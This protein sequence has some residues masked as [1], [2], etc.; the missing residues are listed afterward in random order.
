MEQQPKGKKNFIIEVTPE[1]MSEINRIWMHSDEEPVVE[2]YYSPY[3]KEIKTE[4]Q[5]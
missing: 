5:L 4:E 3:W 1:V 2:L